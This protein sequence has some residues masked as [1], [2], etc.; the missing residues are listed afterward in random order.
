MNSAQAY[1]RKIFP[2]PIFSISSNPNGNK[3]MIFSIMSA[4][5]ALHILIYYLFSN[6]ATLQ[7]NIVIFLKSLLFVNVSTFKNSKSILG[8]KW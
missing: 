1:G 4:N 2:S 7:Y 8:E 5:K 6:N 3:M